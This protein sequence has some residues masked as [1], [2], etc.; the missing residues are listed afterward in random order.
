MEL[1]LA[2][3][4]LLLSFPLLEQ[5]LFRRASAPRCSA[6]EQSGMSE[7]PLFKS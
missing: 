6:H 7:A 3:Q 2:E 4:V 1:V 5:M